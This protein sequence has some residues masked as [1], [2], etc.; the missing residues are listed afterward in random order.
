VY[1]LVVRFDVRPSALAAFDALV[2]SL[3]ADIR[4]HE[5]GTLAY[6]PCTVSDDPHARVFIEVYRDEDAFAAHEAQPHTQEFLRL[7]EPMLRS[8]RVEFLTSQPCVFPTTATA[9]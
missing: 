9:P 3:V 1:S 2:A 8:V 7:R 5:S 6:V 4:A